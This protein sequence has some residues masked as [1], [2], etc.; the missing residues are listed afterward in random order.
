M[1]ELGNADWKVWTASDVSMT[2]SLIGEH[3]ITI[4]LACLED[5][6]EHRPELEELVLKHATMEWIALV[7]PTALGRPGV[8]K[9]VAEA[10]HDYHTRP[11]DHNRLLAALGHA[12]GK[13]CLRKSVQSGPKDLGQYGMVGTSPAMQILYDTLRKTHGTDAPVLI[14]GENG[15]G[16]ELAA[17]AIHQISPHAQGP[18]LAVNCAALTTNLIQTELFGHEKG[19]FT[20]AHQRKIGRIEAAASGTIFLDEIGDLPPE[21]QVN[22]LRFLQERVIE[23]VG[24]TTALHVDARVVVA[25]NIDLEKAVEK[26]A[27]REDLYYRINVLRIRLPPLRNRENDIELLARSYFEKFSKEKKP[28][29]R[30]FSQQALMTMKGYPWPGNVRELI[31]RVRR[32][33][34]MS[35]NQLITAADLGLEKY[36]NTSRNLP[37]LDYARAQVEQ[38]LIRDTLRFNANNVSQTARELGISRATLY[39]L[40]HKFPEGETTAG[41]S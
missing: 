3:G 15:T 9:F 21:L 29:A 26:G 33:M 37:T 1:R 41:S 34:L 14:T 39:R 38:E 40:M 36:T 16:K 20:G 13:V 32:A 35:E 8:R 31:N 23:R 7:S 30:G 25:T 19:A 27:F 24:S 10:F 2:N 5:A 28:V 12:L 6:C 22:L 4:G 11:V 18:F 17:R